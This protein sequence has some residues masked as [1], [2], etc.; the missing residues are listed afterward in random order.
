MNDLIN[1]MTQRMMSEMQE[2]R[3][4]FIKEMLTKKGYEHLIPTE[5][6]RFFKN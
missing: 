3:E 1:E 6:M 5:K 2:K 4:A